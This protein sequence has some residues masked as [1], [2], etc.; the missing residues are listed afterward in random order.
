MNVYGK[1]IDIREFK[2]G[3]FII[4]NQFREEQYAVQCVFRGTLSKDVKVNAWIHIKCEPKYGV[5]IE[6]EHTIKDCEYVI[7][8][9][10][11]LS[12]PETDL[13]ILVNE[14][15]PT[16][17]IDKA[18]DHRGLSLQTRKYYDI[19][20]MQAKLEALFH[21]YFNE[22]QDFISIHTPKIVAG[23]A[24]G[25]TNVFSLDYFGRKAY[26]TQS[27]QLYKQICCAALGRVYEVGPVFRAEKHNTS[28]HLNEYISL[29]VETILKPRTNSTLRPVYQ[30][31]HLEFQFLQFLQTSL[32]KTPQ[33]FELDD[34]EP[35]VLTM[36]EA[37]DILGAKDT[38]LSSEQEQELGRWALDTRKTDAL[39]VTHYHRDVRP[40]YTKISEDGIHT[41][42]FDCIFKGVEITSGGERANTHQEYIDAIAAKGIDPS[43]FSFYLENFRYGFPIHGGFAIGLERLTAKLCDLPSV[44]MA[45]MF[46]RDAER[47]TP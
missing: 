40:F 12:S 18:F 43:S 14:K 46:P 7:E 42:S 47:L 45:S 24:E 37:M 4:L 25:G 30:L 36:E 39:F 26:L 10:N 32:H 2:W 22:L 8:E 3:A 28:R 6:R 21:H 33:W 13:P 20:R 35:L 1:I 11:V 5:K 31:I 34:D 41:E 23:G 27:P 38:D 16:F 29:D 17:S 15:E 44:K 19:F 9:L